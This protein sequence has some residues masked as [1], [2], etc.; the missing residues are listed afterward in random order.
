MK[1]L[2][3]HETG[4]ITGLPHIQNHFFERLCPK[5]HNIKGID[6]GF[7][8]KR[9]PDRK[10]DKKKGFPHI[11]KISNGSGIDNLIC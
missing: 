4:W 2:V 6:Y 11:S 10:I 1:I 9:Y 8:W 7:D 5:G 3:V